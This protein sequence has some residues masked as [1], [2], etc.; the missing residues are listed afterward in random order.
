MNQTMRNCFAVFNGGDI[1]GVLQA[2]HRV[3]ACSSLA[4]M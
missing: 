2:R 1:D 3:L 4:L